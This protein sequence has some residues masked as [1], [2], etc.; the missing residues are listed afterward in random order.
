MV[1]FILH[2]LRATLQSFY[3]YSYLFY[4]D[5]ESLLNYSSHVVYHSKYVLGNYRDNQHMLLSMLPLL[6]FTLWAFYI[7]SESL[8]EHST[9]ALVQS[10]LTP[11]HSSIILHVLLYILRWLR[12]TLEL[13]VIC[14]LSFH[15]CFKKLSRLSTYAIIHSKCVP[16]HSLTNFIMIFSFYIS[17][18]LYF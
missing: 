7:D 14:S 10:K 17:S 1:F 4:S 13:F 8:L 3:T 5:S 6:R 18:E 9:C 12:V 2:R 15:R 11:S 16:S